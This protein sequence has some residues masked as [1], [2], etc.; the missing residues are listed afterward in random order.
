M[1]GFIIALLVVLVFVIIYQIGK[2][3]EYASLMRGEETVKYKTSRVIGWLL[4]AFFVLGVYGIYACHQY[5]QDKMLPIAASENGVQ[6]DLMFEYTVIVTGIVFFATQAL[7]FWFAFRYQAT[8]TR[9]SHFFPHSNKLEIIWTTVPAV[10]MALLVAIGLK[11]WAK[12]TS[13]APANAQVVEVVGKQFNWVVRYPGRDNQLGK[14]DFRKIDMTK[15]VLGMD[16][17]DP[18]NMDDVI[19]ESGELHLVVNKPVKILIGSRDVIHD[20]G[21][22]HFRMKMDAVPGITTTLWF[23]PTVTTDSMK[24]VTGNPNFVYEISCDQMCG[25][26]HYSMRGTIVVQTQAEYDRWMASQKSYYALNNAPAEA[27]A[28]AQDTTG[29]A[30]TAK[31]DSIKAVTMR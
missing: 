10:V 23:T 14:R 4:V 17:N 13:E 31:P 2:A 25:K 24:Q 19:S 22:P 3:S 20:V 6:Y 7:L 16:W 9:K 26:G 28:T 15:N 29:K 1:S 27:P 11:N 21:L 12:F 8:A 30:A 18:H 5:F